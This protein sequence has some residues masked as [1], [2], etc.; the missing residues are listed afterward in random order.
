MPKCWCGRELVVK[1]IGD[2]HDD[3]HP[4]TQHYE[5][6]VHGID[7]KPLETAECAARR[8]RSV[9]GWIFDLAHAL[10]HIIAERDAWRDDAERLAEALEAAKE[11]SLHDQECT[12]RPCCAAG[13]KLRGWA[14]QQRESALRAHESLCEK[15]QKE[16]D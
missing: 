8:L 14:F 7:Y 9:S 15:Y 13:E 3:E 5:C 1:G 12:V 11:V 6:P 16:K 10:G 2:F 4:V